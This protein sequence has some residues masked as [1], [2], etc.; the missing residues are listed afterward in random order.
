[1]PSETPPTAVA[2]TESAIPA[3]QAVAENDGGSIKE[4]A[5]E[6]DNRNDTTLDLSVLIETIKS[7]GVAYRKEEQRE[8]R[9]KKIREWV[10][11]G[12]IFVTFVAVCW[13]VH[14]M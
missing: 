14:E 6:Q 12:L 3:E 11:I 2:P 7:E 8:D 1:M 9:G 4:T 5:S 13:Q 10:T